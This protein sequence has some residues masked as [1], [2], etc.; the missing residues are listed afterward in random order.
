MGKP[1]ICIGKNKDADQLHREA[2]QRLCFRYTDSTILLLLKIRNF[3]LQA[4]FCDCTGP[5]VSDRFGNHIVGF[6][7][8]RLNLLQSCFPFTMKNI[9]GDKFQ[10]GHNF[11]KI[12]VLKKKSAMMSLKHT[13]D[14]GSI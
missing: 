5:F 12:Y 3:K 4:L 8:R 14:A 9:D 2:E 1:T 13:W 6:P 10:N 11:I 7:T